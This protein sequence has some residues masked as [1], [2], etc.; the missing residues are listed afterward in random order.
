MQNIDISIYVP[1]Y[2]GEKTIEKCINSI[3]KQSIKPEKILIINDCS[4]D[5]TKDI[6][7]KYQ[8]NIEIIN[9]DKNLGL[10]YSRNL[11]IN[12]LKSRFIASIDAD[13][14]IN[15]QWLEIL[16][17]KL[18]DK[19]ITLIGGRMFEKHLDNPFNFWRSIR[20]G[21]QW[22]NEDILDPKFVFG[23]NNLLDTKKIN[24][25]KIFNKFAG[26]FKSNGED[27]E[28]SNY[29][30]SENHRLYY[31]SEALCYHLQDD[32]AKSLSKRYWRY[33]HYG[34]GLKKRNYF[35]TIKNLI[36]QLKKTLKWSFIDLFKL[37][38]K[39][40]L[41]NF[42]VFYNFSKIDIR[43]VKEDNYE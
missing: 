25:K 36:R 37:R 16:Y 26:Y 6:L 1:V 17:K 43:F 12:S 22:G 31:S 39:L 32:D 8:D 11:A 13:V 15:N 5:G 38:I 21:Q 20:I 33:I 4:N 27:I 41:I 18:L 29:L 7:E 19:D 3:L 34:D 9:N 10:S 35:K 30:K 14:E 23:C 2:N 28:F 24:K 40:I 42:I